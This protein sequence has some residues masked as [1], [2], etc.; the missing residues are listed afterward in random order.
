MKTES[1]RSLI[2]VIGVLAIAAV[3]TAASI[4]M[5]NTI[6]KNQ[7]HTIAAEELR[8]VAKNTKLLFDMRGDYTGVSVDWLVMAGAFK[9]DHAPLGESWTIEP[10]A[11]GSQFIVNLRG[12]SHGDC[13]FLAVSA[14]SWATS[15]IVNGQENASSP[16]CFSGNTNN[17]SFIAE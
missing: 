14:P 13:D 8:E 9:N 15:I 11:D 10:F 3:M 2:E 17:I 4:A 12:L 7:A 16:I 6:R 5:Y 1:G